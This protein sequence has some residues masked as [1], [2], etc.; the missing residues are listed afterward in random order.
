MPRP[1]QSCAVLSFLESGVANRATFQWL[2]SYVAVALQT[3]PSWHTFKAYAGVY[4]C[5]IKDASD[6][7]ETAAIKR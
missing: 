3:P 2:N 5:P 7:L 6:Y 1:F 4:G